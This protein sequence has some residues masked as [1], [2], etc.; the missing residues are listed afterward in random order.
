MYSIFCNQ[1]VERVRQFTERDYFFSAAE[2]SNLNSDDSNTFS[3]QKFALKATG[4][5]LRFLHGC[6]YLGTWGFLGHISFFIC[7]T[8][9]VCACLMNAGDGFWI[10][11]W[12]ARDRVLRFSYGSCSALILESNLQVELPLLLVAHS[13]LRVCF[14]HS[15]LRSNIRV[16][17]TLQCLTSWYKHCIRSISW[18]F[19]VNERAVSTSFHCT[20]S[21]IF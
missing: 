2:V 16:L 5:L 13:R 3:L 7:R 1:S 17:K 12:F 8:E 9:M 6:T 18:P 15:R 4:L 14:Y 11:W 10:N 20:N 19:E 21:K